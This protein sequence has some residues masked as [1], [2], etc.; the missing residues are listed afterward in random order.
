M[1]TGAVST[2]SVDNPEYDHGTM[3]RL[4][5]IEEMLN[6]RNSRSAV[7]YR[8]LEEIRRGDEATQP[9]KEW[10]ERDKAPNFV[11]V[12]TA[13]NSSATSIDVFDAYQCV[14]GD[15]LRND[16]TGEIMRVSATS[17]GDT[18]AFAATA[19]FG[20][21]FENST[22]AAVLI[23]DNLTKIGRS[24][25]EEGTA[26]DV[27]APVP[28]EHW[29]YPNP[30]VKAWS[31]TSMQQNSKMLDGVGQI[32][33]RWAE[34]MWE[35]MEE[36]NGSLIFSKR[37]R[38]VEAEGNLYTMN[39]LDEQ[40]RTH[41]ID[42]SSI[43]L[44]G[45][46][47]LNEGISP[48]FDAGASSN[49]KVALCGQGAYNT[50]VEAARMAGIKEMNKETLNGTPVMVIEVDGGTIALTK[51]YRTFSGPVL[52]ASM[53]IIDLAH[54]S[55]HYYAGHD[56]QVKANVQ[57]NNEIMTR[58]DAAWFAATLKVVHEDTCGKI[59]GLSNKFN[60]LRS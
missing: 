44:P 15:V 51:D 12:K 11:V 58:K 50:F 8:I 48:L 23:S 52:S 33:E 5:D 36:F 37:N 42:Y 13:A 60:T 27:R 32:D 6:W 4:R 57:G 53:R 29:N 55:I 1:I 35:L 30:V 34:S 25:A 20:R 41:S 26:P 2:Y 31:V 18:L 24:L 22:A 16:R 49:F 59:D 43:V 28:E 39:G 47:Q 54:V 45:W 38:V 17:D 7:F 3:F 19:G 46:S 40:V 14:A 10:A 9:R 21:G 56:L